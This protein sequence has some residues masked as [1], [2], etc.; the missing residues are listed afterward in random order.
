SDLKQPY[1]M[2][3]EKKDRGL[4]KSLDDK[5]TEFFNSGESPSK[6]AKSGN[7]SQMLTLRDKDTGDEYYL[8]TVDGKIYSKEFMDE[9]YKDKMAAGQKTVA[10]GDQVG[11]VS[12][13]ITANKKV[14][15]Y[16]DNT[17]VIT[18]D[19]KSF[20][21]EITVGDRTATLKFATVE[22]YIVTYSGDTNHF[23]M[24]KENGATQPATDTVN[25]NG[26]DLAGTSIFDDAS[27]GNYSSGAAAFNDVLTVV[28][29]TDMGDS[30]W[31]S[32]DG[33]TLANNSFEIINVSQSK[34]AAR[35]QVYTDCKDMLTTQNESILS[36]ITE[37]HS[38][39]VAKLA[40][41]LMEAQTIYQL[42]L[43]VGSRILPPTLAD[44]L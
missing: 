38:T 6:T 19:G 16:F 3:N 14:G 9:G 13:W 27:S 23:S 36:D 41:K 1:M 15:M 43:S 30:S 40:T 39:D 7:L 24:V 26:V 33:K 25:I 10:N 31:M 5:Q 44:Y 11:T 20:S 32:S 8:N 18:D 29:M 28:A 12:D 17:G 35:Q 34:L 22:Q 4:T 21:A 42:S 37:V 2:S